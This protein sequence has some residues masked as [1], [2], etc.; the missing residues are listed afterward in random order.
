MM[1]LILIDGYAGYNMAARCPSFLERD[2][3]KYCCPI[4]I[5]LF[6]Q[7]DCVIALPGSMPHYRGYGRSMTIHI[8]HIP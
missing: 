2:D 5:G 7:Y 1:S 8:V 6:N 4:T 3:K